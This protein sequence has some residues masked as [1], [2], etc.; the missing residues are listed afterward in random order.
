MSGDGGSAALF[1]RQ[2]HQYWHISQAR[3]AEFAVLTVSQWS[4][5]PDALHV[6]EAE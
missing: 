5:P 1:Y 4:A 2:H 6:A 3:N